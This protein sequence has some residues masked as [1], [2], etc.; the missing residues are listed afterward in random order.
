MHLSVIFTLCLAL[1]LASSPGTLGYRA[2]TCNG[3][4]TDKPNIYIQG[5]VPVDN[6]LYSSQTI[7]PAATVACREINSNSSVLG[8]Y[9]LVIEWSDTMVGEEN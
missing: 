8:D 9:E 6:R 4:S 1:L 7:V 3:T 2:P 5:F